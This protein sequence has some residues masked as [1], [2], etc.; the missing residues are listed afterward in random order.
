VTTH[1]TKP[2]LNHTRNQMTEPEPSDRE[3]V[4]RVTVEGDERAFRT[5]Y[6]RHTPA[7]YQF[8]LRTLGG[9]EPEAEDV[10][11]ETWIRGAEGWNAFRWEASLVTWLKSIALNVC[12]SVFRR[13]SAGWLE[14]SDAEPMVSSPAPDGHIDLERALTLLPPGYRTVLLLH[15]LEGYRHDEIADLLGTSAGTSKSQLFRARRAVRRLLA[16]AARE[17]KGPAS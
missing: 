13:R 10:V 6:R 17:V 9:D 14:L 8:A 2:H 15:D 4:R 3:L 12:R 16:P 11:Q 5:L 1:A 7:L